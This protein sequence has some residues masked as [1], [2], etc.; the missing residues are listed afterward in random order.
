MNPTSEEIFNLITA[1]QL[2]SALRGEVCVFTTLSHINDD[3][4]PTDFCELL[5][6]GIYPLV[7]Q[8]GVNFIQSSLEDAIKAICFDALGVFCA[9]KCFYVEII[10]EHAKDSPMFLDRENLPKFLATAFL[11]ASS[12]LHEL[13]IRKGDLVLDRSYKVVLSG[14]RILERDY[15]ID[16]GISLS[17]S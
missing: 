13:E 15:G 2:G 12:S 7:Q 8:Y 5:E 16:W 9:Y 10:S 6:K 11:S 4:R 1:N 3:M 17:K 14:M